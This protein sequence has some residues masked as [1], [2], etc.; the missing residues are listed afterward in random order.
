MTLQV[1]RSANTD[2]PQDQQ[3]CGNIEKTHKGSEKPC[4]VHPKMRFH[5]C[6]GDVL[7]PEDSVQWATDRIYC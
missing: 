3:L 7:E 2:Q 6:R 1:S 5:S 4:C